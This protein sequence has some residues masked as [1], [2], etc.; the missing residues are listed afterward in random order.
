MPGFPNPFECLRTILWDWSY[1]SVGFYD[2]KY[3]PTEKQL[4]IYLVLNVY[5]KKGQRGELNPSPQDKSK[6]CR[7]LAILCKSSKI[8][9]Q[10]D[11][12][13]W[14]KYRN[15]RS[16]SSRVARQHCYENK[17]ASIEQNGRLSACCNFCSSWLIR[18]WG[19]TNQLS[20]HAAPT[21]L[22]NTTLYQKYG[23]P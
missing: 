22:V 19:T 13:W 16:V 6:C 20:D 15:N 8:L 21:D 18:P 23:D 10:W 9:E 5:K 12:K 2:V 4:V 17:A 11:V 7:F 1:I 3:N 14:L